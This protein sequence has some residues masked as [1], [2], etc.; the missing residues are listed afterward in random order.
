MQPT[1][2]ESDGIFNGLFKHSVPDTLS[3]I[4][5]SDRESRKQM[6]KDEIS[7]CM[8]QLELDENNQTT[9]SNNLAATAKSERQRPVAPIMVKPYSMQQ[10][11][12]QQNL[13]YHYAR[14]P[15]GLDENP[16]DMTSMTDLLLK[17]QHKRQ[18]QVQGPLSTASVSSRQQ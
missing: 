13:P 3:S 6:L 7:K 1:V 9:S 5:P 16:A 18:Q 12:Q 10:Q 14:P 15:S 8:R 11:P 17:Y 2:T 4:P